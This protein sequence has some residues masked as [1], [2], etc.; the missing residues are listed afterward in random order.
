MRRQQEQ[1]ITYV[2]KIGREE[3][4]TG[5]IVAM[6]VVAAFFGIFLVGVFRSFYV[7]KKGRQVDVR[8]L[9]CVQ[10]TCRGEDAIGA[11]YYEVTVDFYDLKGETIV[12]ILRS[13]TQY[14]AGDVIRCRYLDKTGIL[15]ME[16]AEAEKI[17]AKSGIL[18]FLI[19]FLIFAAVLG[20]V[21]TAQKRGEWTENAKLILGYLIGAVFTGT[22]ILGIRTKINMA[23]KMQ[24]MVSR[25]GVLVD[26]TT[27]YGTDSKELYSPVYEYEWGGEQRRI[28]SSVSATGKKY[29]TI[30]KKVHILVDPHTGEAFCQEDK[31]TG[32]NMLLLAGVVGIAI[33]VLMLATQFHVLPK[34]VAG[35]GGQGGG[36]P[37]SQ[38]TEKVA[39]VEMFCSYEDTEMEIFNYA[40]AIYEDG[41][42][43]LLLFPMVTRSG[44]GI[45]QEIVFRVSSGDMEKITGWIQR[46]DVEGLTQGPHRTEETEAY[47]SLQ[48]YEDGKQYYGG[49]YCDEGI[50]ADI[51]SLLQTIVP[52]DAWEEMERRETEYYGEPQTK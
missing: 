45:D 43:Q 42:G 12:K 28:G 9:S 30:G 8:V 47:V 31:K 32:A 21:F 33:L 48:I 38:R 52:A 7:L 5:T 46:I 22:G 16:P 1:E 13:D 27:K 18:L 34:S 37:A 39:L 49:G 24:N 35:G 6:I 41:S 2:G 17:S 19:A 23:H 29:R 4:M 25:T 40:A 10:R 51:R 26:Y 44:K 15:Q 11:V 36:S 3:N 14:L 20:L 50:Y